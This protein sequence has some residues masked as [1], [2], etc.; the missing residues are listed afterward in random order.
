MKNYELWSLYNGLLELK[1]CNKEFSPKVN[2]ARFKNLKLLKPYAEAY[3]EAQ[4]E[5]VKKYGEAEGDGS[6]RYKIDPEK[7]ESYLRELRELNEIENDIALMRF[8]AADLE[9]ISLRPAQYDTLA[10]FF[11]EI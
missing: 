8:P 3:M 6:D 2:D 10:E 1:E 11:E 4:S 7:S 5:I 9:G